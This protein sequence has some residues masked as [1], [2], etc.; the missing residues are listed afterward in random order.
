MKPYRNLSLTLSLAQQINKLEDLWKVLLLM[1]A[2]TCLCV[3]V[4]AGLCCGCCK[5][6]LGLA[7]SN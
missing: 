4:G 2:C 3:S 6:R 5:G 7:G 1:L